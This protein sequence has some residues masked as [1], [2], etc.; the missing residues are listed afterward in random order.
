MARTYKQMLVSVLSNIS[1]EKL[2]QAI[3]EC[4]GSIMAGKFLKVKGKQLVKRYLEL[5]KEDLGL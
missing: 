5:I 1:E 2:N 4:F 3:E